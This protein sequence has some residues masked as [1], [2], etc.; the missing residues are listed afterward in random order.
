MHLMI[1]AVDERALGFASRVLGVAQTICA[2]HRPPTRVVCVL[3]EH[4]H[5]PRGRGRLW[6]GHRPDRP[7]GSAAVMAA[8]LAASVR[9]LGVGAARVWLGVT[10]S[11]GDNHVGAQELG[12]DLPELPQILRLLAE[13]TVVILSGPGARPAEL[14]KS[15]GAQLLTCD[16]DARQRPGGVRVPAAAPGARAAGGRQ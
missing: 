8:L 15:L 4:P 5:G 2:H 1:L 3:R 16:P 11:G 13:G 10:P 6:V 7:A 14:A 12:P 9:S